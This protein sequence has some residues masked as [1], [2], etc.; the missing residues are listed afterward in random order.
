MLTVSAA[1]PVAGSVVG[2]ECSVVAEPCG[3]VPGG[4]GP[5]ELFGRSQR[6]RHIHRRSPLREVNARDLPPGSSARDA[7]CDTTTGTS[8]ILSA[9]Q[10]PR[11]LSARRTGI[12]AR[13]HCSRCWPVSLSAATGVVVS[14]S[15]DADT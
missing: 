12:A 13:E 8:G 1:D 9:H 14:T 15:A 7:R 6:V 2:S 10:Y 5:W 11:S 4:S 3:D